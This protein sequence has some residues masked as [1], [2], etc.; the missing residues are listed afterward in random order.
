MFMQI[1]D[2]IEAKIFIPM[3]FKSKS[4]MIKI[5]FIDDSSRVDRR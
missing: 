4:A 5:F 3:I 1:E 2:K